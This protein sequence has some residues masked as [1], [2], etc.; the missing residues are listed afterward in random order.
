MVSTGLGTHANS[1]MSPEKNELY[2]LV[3]TSDPTIID[4][5]GI[6]S[7]PGGGPTGRYSQDELEALGVRYVSVATFNNRLSARAA[8]VAANLNYFNMHGTLP[9]YTF[10]W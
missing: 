8:E 9:K 3:R 7:A 10:R 4:K 5:I 2:H 6:T 1:L